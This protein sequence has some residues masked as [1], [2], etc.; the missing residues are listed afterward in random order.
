MLHSCNPKN[1]T[2]LQFSIAVMTEANND[3]RYVVVSNLEC[4][5]IIDVTLESDTKVIAGKYHSP[6]FDDGPVQVALF[7]SHAS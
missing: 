6:A 2:K 1:I 4:Q 3:N 5:V 7:N